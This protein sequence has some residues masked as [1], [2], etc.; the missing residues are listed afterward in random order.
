MPKRKERRRLVSSTAIKRGG[1]EATP[2]GE[3][4][5]RK[6]MSFSGG[7]REESH[8]S[9][10]EEVHNFSSWREWECPLFHRKMEGKEE[11]L[12][13]KRVFFPQRGKR[14]TPH[15]RRSSLEGS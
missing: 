6:E 13:K 10:E 11:G 7:K 2:K 3:K 15:S 14:T 1:G 12:R 5:K 8:Q 4:N 9:P